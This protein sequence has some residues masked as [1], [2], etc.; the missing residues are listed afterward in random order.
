MKLLDLIH[1]V[2]S[3]AELEARIANLS[4]EKD[5]GE[6]FEEFCVREGV[7]S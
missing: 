1:G 4:L 7:R 6:I 3:W 5:K 2:S